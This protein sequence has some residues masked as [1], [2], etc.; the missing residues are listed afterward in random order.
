MKSSWGR[1]VWMETSKIVSLAVTDRWNR[2]QSALVVEEHKPERQSCSDG[3]QSDREAGSLR[4][5]RVKESSV[6]MCSASSSLS[7][8][9]SPTEKIFQDI[10]SSKNTVLKSS[11]TSGSGLVSRI[12]TTRYVVQT[13]VCIWC[14]K[15]AVMMMMMM[16]SSL[17]SVLFVSS[18]H[19]DPEPPNEERRWPGRGSPSQLLRPNTGHQANLQ[20]GRR[21]HA[22]HPVWVSPGEIWIHSFIHSLIHSLDVELHHTHSGLLHWLC[23]SHIIFSFTLFG[24]F[25]AETLRVLKT[26]RSASGEWSRP[27][28]DYF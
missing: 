11:G 19:V 13:S 28:Y 24:A 4:I 26:R 10:S 6:S 21:R 5:L 23:V 2:C 14:C 16:V 1:L 7:H 8:L 15:Y 22:Q 20:R 17:S 12:W 3:L 9:V 25:V 18:G 27:K